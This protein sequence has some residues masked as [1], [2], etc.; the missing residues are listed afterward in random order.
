M[1]QNE[2][3]YEG[4]QETG[5]GTV[6]HLQ[7]FFALIMLG[8]RVYLYMLIIIFLNIFFKMAG[9]TFLESACL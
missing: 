3:M 4:G 8:V 9:Y 2:S 5:G 6:S 7:V 1:G